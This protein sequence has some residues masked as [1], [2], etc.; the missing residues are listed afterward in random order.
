M[1]RVQFDFCKGFFNSS[2]PGS[3]IK[4]VAILFF[5]IFLFVC[6]NKSLQHTSVVSF[7]LSSVLCN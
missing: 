5:V 3:C 1:Y 6:L 2:V 4:T 7:H